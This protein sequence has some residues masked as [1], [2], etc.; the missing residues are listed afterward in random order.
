MRSVCEGFLR[1]FGHGVD[2]TANAESALKQIR[3]LPY[4]LVL[5]DYR[6]P[7]M[8]GLQ[9]LQRVKEERPETEVIIM[10]AYADVPSAVEALRHHA[11]DYLAKP[12][13][14]EDIQSA[15]Q[16]LERIKGLTLENRLLRR[17]LKRDYT[18]DRIVGDSPAVVEARRLIERASQ[19]DFS[20]LIQGENGTGKE[21]VAKV[22]H[23]NSS[24]AASPFVPV[25]CA[26]IGPNL[27]EGELFGRD[28][29]AAG[30]TTHYRSG[31]LKMADG[32]T[33]FLDDVAEVPVDVQAK[34][35]R[36]LQEHCIRPVGGVNEVKVN[37]R[38]I[39]ATD[40]D[41][42]EL[43]QRG[44]FRQD[45]YYRLNVVPIVLPPLRSRTEDIE[46]LIG[47]F[48]ASRQTGN[49]PL[50]GISRDALEA[51]TNYRW[52]GNIRELE[53]LVERALALGMADQI[54]KE[55]LPPAVLKTS[56]SQAAR[57]VAGDAD[58]RPL[59]EIEKEAILRTL[60]RTG[61]DKMLAAQILGIDR[62]TL[63]RKLKR[64]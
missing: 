49:R 24:R 18:F 20:V 15:V 46:P 1:S 19:E 36:C 28:S 38:V 22:I 59:E 10:T 4:D 54:E 47:H 40:R 35:L 30:G 17:Q 63:Y 16:K 8:D 27:L 23:Y 39:A 26:S 41:L 48:I 37:I 43:I 9:L 13:E 60:E 55:D 61:G 5:A 64:F 57:V 3:E 53:N 50:H 58:L 7:G 21:L 29:G 45:L 2:C 56:Q 42:P 31:L 62:S 52:P 12:F 25:D 44:Q 51:L 14:L 34:L 33:V 6:L 11:F 32:G